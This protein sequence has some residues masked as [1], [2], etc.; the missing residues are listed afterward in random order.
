MNKSTF[1]SHVSLTWLLKVITVR[2]KS[3]NPQDRGRGLRGTNY[4]V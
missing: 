4:Y 1:H 3:V 2:I